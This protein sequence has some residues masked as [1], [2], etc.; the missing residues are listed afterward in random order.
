M[1]NSS[2]FRGERAPTRSAS[3]PM[4]RG[5][6]GA[7]LHKGPNKKI[8]H[9]LLQ[10]ILLPWMPPPPSTLPSPPPSMPPSPPP[11]ASPTAGCASIVAGLSTNPAAAKFSSSMTVSAAVY[12]DN[13]L[14]ART[15]VLAAYEQ[16]EKQHQAYQKRL[17][18]FC[19]QEVS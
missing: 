3:A 14:Y 7:W 5:G 2:S 4:G 12:I 19:P 10:T 13:V 15:G 16:V 8:A 9:R 18:Y 1:T 11:S 17:H 6:P